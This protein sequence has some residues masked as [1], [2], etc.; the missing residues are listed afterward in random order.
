MTLFCKLVE[1][2]R[3]QPII[4]KIVQKATYEMYTGDNFREE[5]RT[6]S[7]LY[8][9]LNLKNFIILVLRDGGGGGTHIFHPRIKEFNYLEKLI[10]FQLSATFGS[11]L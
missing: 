7:C 6:V 11:S 1:A 8:F 2:Y 5:G 4:L 10:S 9:L 3:K